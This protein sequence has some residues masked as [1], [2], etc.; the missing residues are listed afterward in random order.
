MLVTPFGLVTTLIIG[1][2]LFSY[3]GFSIDST[4]VYV[5]SSVDNKR[6]LVQKGDDQQEA[7]DTLARI[8]SKA[9][10][11]I[12]EAEPKTNSEKY[13]MDLLSSRY[14]EISEGTRDFR[15]TSY[16]TNKT[17]ITFCLRIRENNNFSIHDINTLTF[18]AIHELAHMA[19]SQN[20][21]GHVTT[22]FNSNFAFLLREAVRLGIY[23]Y[24]NYSS[25]PQNYCGITISSSPQI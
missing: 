6:Y 20:D 25:N 22:E 14:S 10:K 17:S 7:A 4:L 19:S 24:V 13:A 16:T 9:L 18:V 5:K 15:Y 23:N 2:T 8:N 11:L 1:Y 21:P 3:L 12:H